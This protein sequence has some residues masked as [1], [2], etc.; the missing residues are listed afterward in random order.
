MPNPEVL[1]A[2][3]KQLAIMLTFTALSNSAPSC[4]AHSLHVCTSN[5]TN[6]RGMNCSTICTMTLSNSSNLWTAIWAETSGKRIIKC[7]EWHLLYVHSI[8]CGPLCIHTRYNSWNFWAFCH[9]TMCVNIESLHDSYAFSQT[10]PTCSIK[11]H[12]ILSLHGP[13]LNYSTWGFVDFV[14]SVHP[15]CYV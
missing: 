14:F 3:I 5:C 7:I 4:E 2:T 6:F 13:V 9:V 8:C 10:Y 11:M 12:C 15:F 1:E